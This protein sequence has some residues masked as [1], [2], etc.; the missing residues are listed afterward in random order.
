M[1]AN[2][3]FDTSISRTVTWLTPAPDTGGAS[4]PGPGAWGVDTQDYSSSFVPD[5]ETC[6]ARGRTYTRP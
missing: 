3:A 5:R 4:Y 6:S 2:R 1:Y